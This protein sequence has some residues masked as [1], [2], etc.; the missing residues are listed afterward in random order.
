M[1]V[2][3]AADESVSVNELK[4]VADLRARLATLEGAAGGGSS[5]GSGVAGDVKREVAKRFAQWAAVAI[6]GL[7]GFALL[8]WWFYIQ[9]RL[10]DLVGGVPKNGVVA[11]DASDGCPA[12]WSPFAEASGRFIIGADDGTYSYRS[13]GGAAKVALANQELPAHKHDLNFHFAFMRANRGQVV[14]LSSL[15]R[16]NA[17]ASPN[18]E[19]NLIN[20]SGEA[21]KS[22]TLSGLGEAHDN[23]PPYLALHFCKK[24]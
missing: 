2:D 22:T 19:M 14:D 15:P 9:P 1:E 12:N 20:S 17:S 3:M 18:P 11:F 21:A 6:L 23:I 10:V 4:E 13:T 5:F 24:N 16:I 7:A 8:G